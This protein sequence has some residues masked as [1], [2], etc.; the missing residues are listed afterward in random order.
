ME[1]LSAIAVAGAGL[2]SLQLP[3]F[4]LRDGVWVSGPEAG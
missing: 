3:G 1:C 2:A 4:L